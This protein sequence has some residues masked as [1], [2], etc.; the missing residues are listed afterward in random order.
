MMHYYVKYMGKSLTPLLKA[1]Y[2]RHQE[3]F[4]LVQRNI[5]QIIQDKQKG[6]LSDADAQR[7]QQQAYQILEDRKVFSGILMVH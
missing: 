5:I 4:D 7:R 6:T 3:T 1:T 2:E